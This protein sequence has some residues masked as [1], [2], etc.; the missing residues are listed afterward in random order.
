[1][2]NNLV[3]TADTTQSQSS[4][5]ALAA[6]IE[7]TNKALEAIAANTSKVSQAQDVQNATSDNLIQKFMGMTSP[8][9]LLQTGLSK[10]G[11]AYDDIKQKI[12]SFQTLRNKL[13]GEK[14][15]RDNLDEVEALAASLNHMVSVQELATSKNILMKG[16]MKLSTEEMKTVYKAAVQ[17]SRDTGQLSLIHI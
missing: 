6:S 16:A 10:L 7:K 4:M 5:Q 17:I 2:S 9:G 11:A 3:L 1:M 12:V 14:E 15:Y 13:G 8:L